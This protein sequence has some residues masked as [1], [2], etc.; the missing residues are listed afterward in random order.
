MALLK[1]H[2]YGGIKKYQ[3]PALPLALHGV[4]VRADGSKAEISFGENPEEPV[5]YVTDLLIHL[6][7]DQM[8]KWPNRKIP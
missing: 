1:T 5:L 6:A 3:W 4:V 8:K 7:K 2:Y